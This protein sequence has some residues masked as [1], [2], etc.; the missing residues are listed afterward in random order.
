MAGAATFSRGCVASPHH[1]AS[2]AG[3]DVLARDG[4]A[5]DAA[6]AANLVLA[7]VTPYHCGAG[8][9][10]FAIVWD[11]DRLYGY[12]GSGRAPAAATPEAVRA[13]A[14]AGVMPPLGG[15]TVTVPGAVAGWF[16]LLERFGSLDFAA[17]CAPARELAAEGFEVSAEGAAW[18]AGGAAAFAGEERWSETFSRVRTGA[19]LRQPE[20]ARALERLATD[21]PEPLY[22][23]EIAGAL[24]ACVRAGGGLLDES[25]L[26]AH[27]G[28]WVEPL[29]LTYGGSELVE[30]PPNSQGM[31]AQLAL[32]IA[33]AAGAGTGA[34]DHLLI[35][36]MKLAL[37]D[38]DAHLT[39]PEWMDVSPAALLDP[40]RLAERA[41]GIAPD[42][43]APLPRPG[44]PATGGTAYLCAADERGACVSLI[45][46]NY[47][48]FGSGL[49]VP[50]FGIGLHNRGAYFSLDPSHR[51]VIAP[52]KRTL[53][54]LM[55]A[56]V[57]RGGRP[58]YVLGTM[59]ADAQPSIQVQ[60][61]RALVDRG[62]DVEQAV[63]APRWTVSPAD[64]SVVAE[65]LHPELDDLARRGHAVTVL[66]E[67]EHALGHAHAIEVL[68]D[69][70]HAGASDPRTESG[71]AGPAA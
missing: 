1:L 51:N 18:F 9:D 35:E 44:R 45:Q 36:A 14:G 23:G 47:S 26:A 10:L 24:A 52:R 39:D 62:H 67:R 43:A 61:V 20:L 31:T 63:G 49:I 56:M 29:S 5:V 27:G 55:P 59:G 42:R 11:G 54:T 38:R 17:V 25:D 57:L 15:L 6:I 22:R 68:E 69:G 41:A 4:N 37:A 16:D 7:V 58:R 21:G 71:V 66:G 40:G 50:G 70:R 34:G 60:L 19:S 33:Q 48:G 12:N 13:A 32:G 46:S 30:L 64:G 28:E 53:H 8:G 3:S 2:R 65:S